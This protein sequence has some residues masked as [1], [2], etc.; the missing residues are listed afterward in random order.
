MSPDTLVKHLTS[1]D[2][3]IH[4]IG[5]K[6]SFLI[7]CRKSFFNSTWPIRDSDN[8]TRKVSVWLYK[9]VRRKREKTSGYNSRISCPVRNMKF[10]PWLTLIFDQ[11]RENFVCVI[12]FCG[13]NLSINV[14][15]TYDIYTS[16]QRWRICSP[17]LSLQVALL[18]HLKVKRRRRNKPILMGYDSEICVSVYV[19]WRRFYVISVSSC[20]V[21]SE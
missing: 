1:N 2:L 9:R 7:S 5:R 19:S 13:C 20:K 17:L 3:D 12:S 6:F 11:R 14:H 8:L 21:W 15:P 18:I 16:G 10:G 4:N